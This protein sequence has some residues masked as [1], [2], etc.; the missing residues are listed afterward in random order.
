M[1]RR[2]LAGLMTAA[3]IGSLLW[4]GSRRTADTSILRMSP[5]RTATPSTGAEASVE[6]LLVS[7]S[8]G[9]VAAYL[10]G[11]GGDARKRIEREVTE[12]E[13][14]AFAADLR[15]AAGARKSHAVFAGEP[16]PDGAVRVTVETVYADRNERQT[17]RVERVDGAWLVTG[18]ESVRG[19]EPNARYGTT[20]AYEVPE[21]VPVQGRIVV[22]TGTAGD[23]GE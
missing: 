16:E 13:R 1:M 3:L 15:R 12:R 9:D 8:S 14:E 18:V 19:H 5:D 10:A 4:F 6:S 17:Y 11:F 21:G 22:E 23:R 2:F 7:A 20:A